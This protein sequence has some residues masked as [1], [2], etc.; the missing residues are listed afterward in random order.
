MEIYEVIALNDNDIAKEIKKQTNV[1]CTGIDFLGNLLALEKYPIANKRIAVK[2]ILSFLAHLDESLKKNSTTV[3]A[4]NQEIL[5]K[6]FSRDKYVDYVNLLKKMKVMTAV[7][8]ENG[9]FYNFVDKKKSKQYRIHSEFLNQDLAL[10]I[11]NA[12]NDIEVTIDG[13]FDKKMV[14]TILNIEVDLKAAIL[15]E[16]ANKQSNNSL[17]CRLSILLRLYSVRWV[18]TGQ[19]VDR[20]YHSLSNVSRI[21][22]KHIHIKGNHFH[23]I[24]I[25][26]CQPLL[27]CYLLLKNGLEVDESYKKDCENGRL[28]ERFIEEGASREETKVLLYKAIYFAFKPKRDIALKFKELYPATFKSLQVISSD[29]IKMATKLQNLEASIFNKLAPQKSKNYFTLFDA[30]YFTDGNDILHLTKDIEDKFAAFG[31]KPKLSI[32]E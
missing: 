27:L 22:R 28:Y 13:K 31:I 12:K 9:T 23:N 24:D 29:E 32:N 1:Y 19:N 6:Y 2:N 15:D 17:R 30:I 7:P 26:N 10:L 16:V 25:K 11:I 18:K 8:Y 3:V 5:I 4:I 14:K 20:I 21:S